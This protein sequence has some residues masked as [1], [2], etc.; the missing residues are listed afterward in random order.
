MSGEVRGASMIPDFFFVF[1]NLQG[2]REPLAR[3][4]PLFLARLPRTSVRPIARGVPLTTWQFLI[5]L[6]RTEPKAQDAIGGVIAVVFVL[7]V[8]WVLG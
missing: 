7:T 3:R 5:H 1:S 4:E 2:Q 6:I 8:L